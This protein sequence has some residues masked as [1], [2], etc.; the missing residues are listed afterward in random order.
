MLAQP[1]PTVPAPQLHLW[2]AGFRGGR[3]AH[4]GCLQAS[5]QLRW[6]ARLGGITMTT[7]RRR[8]SGRIQAALL[9]A[10]ASA[11]GGSTTGCARMSAAVAC[12]RPAVRALMLLPGVP[13][14]VC[15]CRLLPP[16]LPALCISALLE[17]N[18]WRAGSVHGVKQCGIANRGNWE[19]CS[20][21]RRHRPSPCSSQAAPAVPG[22]RE[23]RGQ[24]KPLLMCIRG[25]PR[26]GCKPREMPQLGDAP[27]LHDEKLYSG[28]V[29]GPSAASRASHL[30]PAS[31]A[32][33]IELQAPPLRPP[34]PST[35]SRA[36]SVLP[37]RL[38]RS[39]AQA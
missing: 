39:P 21:A 13:A 22:P 9:P 34:L 8:H 17:C 26:L 27:A 30:Q 4:A 2:P 20:C 18:A 28:A 35:Q 1:P 3:P 23:C 10:H 31:S 37:P 7:T 6:G 33:R 5:R 24:Q 11:P 15:T 19:G 32:A 12:C 29:M 38:T 36:R 16:V 25:G 14:A